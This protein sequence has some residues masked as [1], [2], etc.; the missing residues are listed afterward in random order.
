[1]CSY[2]C[3]KGSSPESPHGLQLKSC[4]HQYIDIPPPSLFKLFIYFILGCA[5]PLVLHSGFL[6]LQQ[7]GATLPWGAQASHCGGFSCDG[8][9]AV[10]CMGLVAL[11]HVECSRTRDG[12]CV[13]WIGRR[14]LIHCTTQEVQHTFFSSNFSFQL[15]A[16]DFL[17]GSSVM[18]FL[19]SILSKTDGQVSLET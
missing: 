17:P 6:S 2:I 13:P 9:R 8:T 14:I 19:H 18:L 1:M 3:I 15:V 12:T 11:Q 10:G 16:R 7:A 4:L 5:W